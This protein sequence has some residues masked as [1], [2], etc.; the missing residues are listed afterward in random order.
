MVDENDILQIER[1]NTIPPRIRILHKGRELDRETIDYLRDNA[2]TFEN[3]TLWKILS[4]EVKYQANQRMYYKGENA[5]DIL[6]GRLMNYILD[7]IQ[8]KINQIKKL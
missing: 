7:I 5:D 2:K 4:N 6:A 8:K 3:S 1:L